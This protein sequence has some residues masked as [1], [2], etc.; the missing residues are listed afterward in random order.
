M[1]N[2]NQSIFCA[3]HIDVMSTRKM[4]RI[5]RSK[6]MCKEKTFADWIEGFA[7]RENLC[8]NNKSKISIAR[9]F[10]FLKIFQ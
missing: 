7:G 6:E 1:H 5:Q 8:V 10:E 9:S 2:E 4:M 3:S